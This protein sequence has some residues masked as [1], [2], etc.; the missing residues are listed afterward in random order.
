VAKKT[1]LVKYIPII[2]LKPTG[3]QEIFY[4]MICTL[5]TTTIL[6]WSWYT[7]YRW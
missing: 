6:L 4:S 5:R 7:D 2:Y 3:L 1:W